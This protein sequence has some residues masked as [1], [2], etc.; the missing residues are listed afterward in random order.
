MHDDV[1][2][3]LLRSFSP[4]TN[5]LDPI[6]HFS[7]RFPRHSFCHESPWNWK[8]YE[9]S[10][11]LRHIAARIL[12]SW[13]WTR[14][15]SVVQSSIFVHSV[16][17]NRNGAWEIGKLSSRYFTFIILAVSLMIPA[18]LT[19]VHHNFLH[20]LSIFASSWPEPNALMPTFYSPNGLITKVWQN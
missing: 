6:S 15:C 14:K 16:G 11:P 1:H 17:W 12:H 13:G 2:F 7:R 20:T 8:W 19:L 10:S 9:S 5:D 18:E 4:Q 3:S